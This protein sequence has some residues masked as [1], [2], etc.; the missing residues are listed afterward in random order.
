MVDVSVVES[1]TGADTPPPGQSVTNSSI[2]GPSIQ[3]GSVGGNVVLAVDR[4]DYQLHWLERAAC[5]AWVPRRLRTPSYLLDARQGVVPYRPRLAVQKQLVAWRDAPGVP[6]SVLL[7]HGAGGLGKTRLANAFAGQAHLDGWA[8]AHAIHRATAPRALLTDT[9]ASSALSASAAAVTDKR[10]LMLVAVDYAER[11]DADALV[12]LI[13]GL[14]ADFPGRVI[15]VLLLA[16]SQVDLWSQLQDQ[17]DRAPTELEDPIGLGNLTS[18]RQLDCSW[19][20]VDDAQL[21][22]SSSERK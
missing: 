12:Q 14:P 20:G 11:W 1:V 16:R 17:L 3:I 8:V 22:N 10:G 7:V 4:P 21:V 2:N 19:S 9:G 6:M 18:D 13:I 15:R 5:D